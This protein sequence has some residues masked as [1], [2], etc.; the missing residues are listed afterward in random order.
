MTLAIGEPVD[1]R[2]NEFI[3][4]WEPKINSYTEDSDS[5]SGKELRNAFHYTIMFLL[6]LPILFLLFRFTRGYGL[7]VILSIYIG[8][9]LIST[10]Q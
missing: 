8:Y 10:S 9:Y 7:L 4:S 5:L 3:D 6:S 1:I 2:Y